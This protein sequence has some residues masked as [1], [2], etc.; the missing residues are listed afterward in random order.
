MNAEQALIRARAKGIHIWLT[1]DGIRCQSDDRTLLTPELKGW[2]KR[3]KPVLVTALKAEREGV[4]ERL[5]S[6]GT[7]ANVDPALADRA[8]DATLRDCIGESDVVLAE[9]MHC[10]AVDQA[11]EAGRIPAGHDARVWCKRCGPVFLSPG[12]ANG[13]PV[14]DGWPTALACPWCWI[15]R[16]NF[17]RPRVTC[18][19]CRHF[20]RDTINPA[21]GMGDCSKHLFKQTDYRYPMT[22][23]ECHGFRPTGDAS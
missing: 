20:I 5:R 12:L 4:R 9:L 2:V 23:R 21:D 8:D 18:G 15:E 1:N 13:L 10:Y 11:R 19:A 7:R 14:K 16:R 3:H 17:P 22:R 6:A